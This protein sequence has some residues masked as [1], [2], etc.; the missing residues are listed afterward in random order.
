[1]ETR[2]PKRRRVAAQ[3]RTRRSGPAGLRKPRK[4][5][6][7]VRRQRPRGREAVM[8]AVLDAATALFTTHGPASVSVRD[9]A[10][11]AGVNHALVHRHFGSKHEVLRA[12][13]ER[14]VREIAAIAAEITDAR[15]G[16]ER[17]FAASAAHETYWR[18]LARALLDGEN[19]RALQRDFPTVRRLITLLEME[20]Q[21][22]RRLP[23]QPPPSLS[24]DVPVVVGTLCALMLGWLVFEPFLL[25]ATGLEQ[26]DREEVRA[27]VIRML[28]T[29]VALTH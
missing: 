5:E 10:A 28:Q 13:L 29:M 17:L 16:M 25:T 2:Q 24:C 12:V 15:A 14:T 19:P 3:V 11:A 23:A 21:Q 22:R 6:E 4:S 18:A 27:Q 26:R 20:R 7:G 8:A 1:M 9:I